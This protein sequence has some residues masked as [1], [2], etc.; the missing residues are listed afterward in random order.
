MW[1]SPD[2]KYSVMGAARLEEVN[3]VSPGPRVKTLLAVDF[4]VQHCLRLIWQGSSARPFGWLSA[5]YLMRGTEMAYAGARKLASRFV[6]A[7]SSSTSRWVSAAACPAVSRLLLGRGLR[8]GT[9]AIATHFDPET[10]V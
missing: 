3:R 1:P 6:T 2:L 4:A 9:S 7:L 10:C 5:C 8:C